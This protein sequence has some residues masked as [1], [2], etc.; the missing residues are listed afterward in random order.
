M[1]S[2]RIKN[3]QDNIFGRLTVIKFFGTNGANRALWI[4]K[5]RCGKTKT[6]LSDSLVSGRTKSCGCLNVEQIKKAKTTHGYANKIPEYRIWKS[7]TGRCNNKNNESF[8]NYGGR[9]I[10][11]CRRWLK[12]ENFLLD[13]GKRPS[14]NHSIDRLNN[15][16]GYSKNNCRWATSNQQNRNKR[17]NINILFNGKTQCLKDWAKELNMAY[18]T[19]YDRI[20][21][22]NWSVDKALSTKSS[23]TDNRTNAIPITFKGKTQNLAKWAKEFQINYY[24]LWGRIYKHGMSMERALNQPVRKV[25]NDH[26]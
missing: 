2:K 11:V 6:I 18:L 26:N 5:C 15:D 8:N 19:L 12:F 14:K 4:C 7:M 17:S 16:D 10:R 21:K 1:V 20:H 23:R 13:M 24:T 22:L 9:G 3:L 25:K